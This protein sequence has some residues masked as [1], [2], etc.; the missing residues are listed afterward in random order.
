MAESDCHQGPPAQA[1]RADSCR[2]G[3][4]R[5]PSPVELLCIPIR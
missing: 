1:G 5:Q 3:P 2:S 4:E